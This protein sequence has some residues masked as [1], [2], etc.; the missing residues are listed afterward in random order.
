MSLKKLFPLFFLVLLLPLRSQAALSAPFEVSG[1][2]PY[3]RNATG[4]MEFLTHI[5]KFK[6]IN[7][8]GYTV[9]SDGTLF[10]ASG[11]SQAPWPDLEK[12]AKAK[13][14]RFVPTVMWSDGA[15][16]DKILRNPKTRAAHIKNIVSVVK[17]NN[18]DGIDIDYEAKLAETQPYFSAFLKELYAAMGPKWVEC[19]IEARTPADSR[20][21]PTPDTPDQYAN[22]YKAIGKYCDRVRLMAYDQASVDQKL[23]LSTSGPYV[24]VAD[25]KWVEKVVNLAAQSIPKSKITLGVATYGYEYKVTPLTSGYDYQFLWAFNPKYATDLAASLGLVPQRNV[26]GELSL[27]YRPSDATASISPSSASAISAAGSALNQSFNIL[28]WSDASAIKDKVDL[29]K[30]LGLRGISIFKIDG[31]ADPN[32]WSVLP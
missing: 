32:L 21:D 10:D 3:W 8:F 14:I 30:R 17:A 25:P 6:E 26:A 31:G 20:R 27:T 18:F 5:D 4:T 22:D 2:I 23:T 1:W 7:P 29:A 24:P 11:L 15:T 9:K 16:I 12:L 28:W 19:D 13:Q